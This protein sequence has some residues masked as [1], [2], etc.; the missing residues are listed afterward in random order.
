M[1]IDVTHAK[2]RNAEL[3]FDSECL[4]NDDELPAKGSRFLSPAKVK[5]KYYVVE[6]K[7]FFFGK[8]GLVYEQPCDRCLKPVT[9]HLDINF[10]EIF[11]RDCEDDGEFYPYSGDMLDLKPAVLDAIR[12]NLPSQVLCKEDCKGLCTKCGNDL[13]EK[14]CPCSEEPDEN[15]PF[16][17]LFQKKE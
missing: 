8:I 13:N 2:L 15:N 10:N 11:V 16:Y 6:D 14:S 5:G 3:D 9:V 17:V 12:L 1:L 7:L 4:V